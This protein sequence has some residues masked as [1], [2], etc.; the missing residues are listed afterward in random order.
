VKL[1]TQ[2]EHMLLRDDPRPLPFHEWRARFE[3]THGRQPG[4]GECVLYRSILQLDKDFAT[5][6]AYIKD[7]VGTGVEQ[8]S[9]SN[10]QPQR[11]PDVAIGA[12][13]GCSGSVSILDLRKSA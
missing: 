7:H 2:I 9:L 8:R 5:A 3:G 13:A 10:T 1:P 6:L 12:P 4:Q 11:G